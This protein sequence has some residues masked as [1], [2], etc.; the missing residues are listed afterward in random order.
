MSIMRIRES[1]M[2]D[3]EL[4]YDQDLVNLARRALESMERRKEEDPGAWARQLA[5]DSVAAGEAEYAA[6]CGTSEEMKAAAV[7]ESL[8][9]SLTPSVQQDIKDYNW[10]QVSGVPVSETDKDGRKT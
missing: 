4:E 3:P 5:E 9:R 6:P 8:R 1:D 7:T 2:E 10:S